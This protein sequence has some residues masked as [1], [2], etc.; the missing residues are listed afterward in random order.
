MNVPATRYAKAGDVSIAYQVI[1][2][3]QLDLVYAGGFASH[4]E[5]D[6]EM[7][8]YA[9]WLQRLA[10]FSRLF[11]FDKRGTGLS[12]PVAE[13]PTLEARMDDLRAVLDAEGSERAAI[14]GHSEG[15]PMSI[16]FAATYPERVSHLVLIGAFAR[17]TEAEDYPFGPPA[18]A[19]AEAVNRY[20]Q[21]NWGTGANIEVFGPSIADDPKVIEMTAKHERYAASPAMA[22]RIFEMFLNIDVRSVVP[23][24]HV[25]TLVLHRR[26]DR[27]VNRRAGKWIADRLPGARYVLL[28]G[29]DHLPWAGD[30]DAIVDQIQQFLTGTRAV[31]EPDRVLATVLFTDIVGST[32]RLAQ[33][34]DRRWRALMGQCD[35]AVHAEIERFQGT[36]VKSTGDGHMATFDG[37]ARAIRCAGAIVESVRPLGLEL[38]QGLH[39]GEV[40]LLG[41]DVRG[42]AVNTA[43]RVMSEA[44]GSEVLVS[45]TV[46]DLVA[47]SG[48]V[49]EDRGTHTLKGMPDE[50]HLY[51]VVAA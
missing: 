42:I 28:D 10:S 51:A 31:V 13:T 23:T 41:E 26:G 14:I 19:I 46:K 7:P 50:W 34:G 44:E 15:A 2:E 6:W 43:A 20:M 22:Q 12:D 1:G 38:R 33:L 35:A 29:Q 18:D 9:R 8:P 36:L 25:P 16:L 30:Q 27:V 39:A 5:V 37:P 11:V 45:S 3:G 47:G 48:I 32:Q 49:F 21:P 4:L 17:S 40:E 24:I